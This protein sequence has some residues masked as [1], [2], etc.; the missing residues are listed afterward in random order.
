MTPGIRASA[1]MLIVFFSGLA[2]PGSA[3]GTTGALPAEYY[4]TIM[5]ARNMWC[6]EY[7]PGF[8]ER[9]DEAFAAFQREPEIEA[10]KQ[11]P[12]Y[13]EYIDAATQSLNEQYANM[14]RY[15]RFKHLAVKQICNDGLIAAIGGKPQPEAHFSTPEKTL[16]LYYEAISRRD[17]DTATTCLAPNN[18]KGMLDIF[19]RIEGLHPYEPAPTQDIQ[20]LAR[21]AAAITNYRRE[22]IDDET[23]RLIPPQKSYSSH[24]LILILGN[25]KISY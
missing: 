19:M 13:Q 6:S 4:L 25:W 9:S 3:Y 1:F 2:G 5:I 11:H 21:R 22:K 18:K 23:I 15:G 20:A 17:Y 10:F 14:D 16:K 7:D 24:T 8:R 12:R